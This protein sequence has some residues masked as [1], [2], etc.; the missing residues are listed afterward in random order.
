MWKK[1]FN[2]L[3]KSD[4]GPLVF[5]GLGASIFLAVSFSLVI[6]LEPAPQNH[7][8][9]FPPVECD[10]T[11]RDDGQ[12]QARAMHSDRAAPDRG[13]A[14]EAGGGTMRTI[15]LRHGAPP[16]N[17]QMLRVVQEEGFQPALRRD[18]LVGRGPPRDP[19]ARPRRRVSGAHSGE[20]D[21]PAVWRTG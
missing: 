21:A 13:R 7:D 12:D 16:L 15:D 20:T 6:M 10:R 4:Y 18:R 9:S 11:A 5:L 1:T 8:K 3:F 14:R 19:Y 17:H 2:W